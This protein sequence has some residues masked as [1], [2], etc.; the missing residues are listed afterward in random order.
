MDREA[1]VIEQAQKE[2]IPAIA[3]LFTAAFRESVLYYC[4][5]LPEPKAMEDV[6]TLVRE[7]EPE[8]AL[9]ARTAAGGIIGYCFAPSELSGL[10]RRGICGGHLFFWAW[11]WL[12]GQYGFRFRPL[13]VILAG[14]ISFF[15]SALTPAKAADAR[16]LSIAVAEDWRGRKVAQQLMHHALRYLECRKVSRVRLE[17]RPDNGPAVRVYEKM[18]FVAGGM[19]RDCQGPW[20]IM[21]KEMGRRH[22]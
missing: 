13:L 15:R 14:K 19:T 3:A 8:A 11:R 21:F 6:F 10:W 9:V 18:G 16:I 1:Y 12:T 17:V 5:S 4:G 2:D 22:V 20:L 7:S